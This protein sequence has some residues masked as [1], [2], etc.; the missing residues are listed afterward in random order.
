MIIMEEQ[1]KM[2]EDVFLKGSM[3]AEKQTKDLKIL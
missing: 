3:I 2:M 1:Q